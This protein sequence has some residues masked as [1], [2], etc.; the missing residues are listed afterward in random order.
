[1]SVNYVSQ[2]DA[3][4]RLGVSRQRVSQLVESGQ[5]KSKEIAG[6][7]VISESELERFAAIPRK[8]GRPHSND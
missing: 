1:M 4:E 3:A 7:F 5:L 8:G 6:R 2:T